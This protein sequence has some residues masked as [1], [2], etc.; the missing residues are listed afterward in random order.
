MEPSEITAV[1]D[2]VERLAEEYLARR[3]RGEQPTVEEY[4][5]RNPEHAAMIL[6]LFPALE[7]ME[8]LKP[9]PGEKSTAAETG[10]GRPPE[11]MGEYRILRLLGRGGMGIVYEAVQ[12][13]LG[14]HVALKVLPGHVLGDPTQRD[15]FRL[16]ARSVA[17]LHH[18]NIVPVFAVGEH[19]GVPY[20]AMQF[21]AGHSLEVIL[22][23]LR[24]LRG[25]AKHGPVRLDAGLAS[26]VEN[27]E[28][29]GLARSLLATGP[30][31]EW[32]VATGPVPV[33]EP[34][35]VSP[36]PDPLPRPAPSSSGSAALSSTAPGGYYRAAARI[37]LQVAEA[38]AHAHD[39]GVLHRDIKPSNLLLDADGR[40]W[41][42]DFGLAKLEGNEG[43][44][45]SGD[46]VGTLRYMPP[47][48][49][50]GWSD[51]RSDLYALGA[52][53]YELLTL[54][55]AF[56]ATS[57][58]QLVQRVL[59]D[60]PTTPRR[61]DARIPRDLETLTLKAIAREPADRYPTAR[62]M[63]DDLRRFLEDRP[64]AARR[65]RLIEHIWRWCRRNPSV[66]TLLMM[67]AG[68]TV[69]LAVGSTIVAMQ[70][71]RSRDGATSRLWETYR[72]QARA[73]RT[74]R[75]AG[76]RFEGLESLSLAGKIRASEVLRDELIASLALVDLR[77]VRH[78]STPPAGLAVIAFDERMER[79]A[80]S[81]QRG[82]IAV[83]RTADDRELVRL[84]GAGSATS[85]LI[86]LPGGRQLLAVYETSDL[87]RLVAWDLDS[88]QELWHRTLPGTGIGASPDGR[89]IAV[90][91][92]E[93]SID[94]LDA[95]TGR[96]LY[97]LRLDLWFDQCAFNP[98]GGLLAVTTAP[99]RAV[100]VFDV[101]REVVV[102]SAELDAPTR[103]VAWSEDGRLL[104]VGCDD[105]RIHVW[106]IERKQLVSA[107]V[108][109]E[110]CITRLRFVG[111]SE[112]LLSSTWDNATKVWDPVRGTMLV[113]TLGTLVQ[114]SL[115]GRRL[116]MVDAEMRPGVWELAPRREF[117]MLQHRLA[118]N[119]TTRPYD[120]NSVDIHCDGRLLTSA[121]VDGVVLWDTA[122]GVQLAH[123]DIGPTGSAR[124]SPDGSQM[125]TLGTAGLNVWPVR[126]VAG[127]VLRIGPPNLVAYEWGD[128]E[129]NAV[130][131]ASGRRIAA[132][133]RGRN[134]VFVCEMGCPEPVFRSGVHPGIRSVA[135]APDGRLVATGTWRGRNV[136]VWDVATGA[137]VWEWQCISASVAFSPDGRW[138]VT[139]TQTE[140]PGPEP[141]PAGGYRLWEVGT[142]RPGATIPAAGPIGIVAFT[143]DGRLMAVNAAEGRVPFIDSATGRTVATL[144]P[145]PGAPRRTESLCFSPD[146]HYLALGTSAGVVELWDLWLL[147]AEL[148]VRGQN[149]P[150]WPAPS[151][152]S[153]ELPNVTL[154][155]H[156]KAADELPIPTRRTMQDSGTLVVQLEG[157]EWF[158]PARLGAEHAEAGRWNE[159]ADAYARAA[160]LRPGDRTVWHRHLLL[161]LKQGD[162]DGYRRGCAEARARL[163][164]DAGR[165]AINDRTW[166][167]TLG[168]DVSD[169]GALIGPAAALASAHPDDYAAQNTLG[170][171][172][173]RAG[174][175]EEASTALEEAIRRHGQGGTALD[176][177]FLAMARHHLGR[178]DESRLLLA[179]ADDWIRRAEAGQV[180]LPAIPAPL[181]WEVRLELD[182][183]RSEA[184]ALVNQPARRVRL[185]L[186][187]TVK[188]PTPH[189]QA[190]PFQTEK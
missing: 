74:S 31:S 85:T 24:Q 143:H 78:L 94:V 127:P 170:A 51:P 104:A 11:R 6:D 46:L 115:D 68:L 79:Y 111:G 44:T 17:R 40:V 103:G 80:I 182:L 86:F 187:Q 140:T 123:L 138:L 81:D 146:D 178:D 93:G 145:P 72:A 43:P 189:A 159:A 62:A 75:Q 33:V 118:G 58:E 50:D 30:D 110:N 100:R 179:R 41:V 134:Q 67:V 108:G 88:A 131:D 82:Q 154:R 5:A 130:W 128:V 64:V 42:T 139:A 61:L 25:V 149:W 113:E 84:A 125:L 190:P 60:T 109:H 66:A 7:L 1:R 83:L 87:P 97:G 57:R 150:G 169:L 48:R 173:Y 177:I 29:L 8:R 171:L 13:T 59:N 168:P 174:Q 36:E 132:V 49:F 52:T 101:D 141:A 14:R 106:D 114:A 126:L 117:R 185:R 22:E 56:D 176:D 34:S 112:L 167:C 142:W 102:W 151:E 184:D 45:R 76:Q 153:G 92:G 165:N 4:A 9:D 120:L 71:N 107:L 124:F 91:G 28:S 98:S 119:R 65:P 16:E 116:G 161:R 23:D 172:L 137:Q 19:Q 144:D 163:A 73:L 186:D 90:A 152:G 95:G 180:G 175:Y 27:R 55:P 32:P 18:T 164:G 121:S 47:E 133:S 10:T 70:L 37:G 77:L 156:V 12:E 53:L 147:R 20:F 136:K 122:T 162:L 54:R 63:A 158:T 160:A 15:R 183:L 155:V 35:N 69:A 89:R 129:S 39:H 181:P 105:Y 21:I 135:I 2:P 148:A 157:V 96:R 99:D 3:R 26:T 188:Q 38:L 166:F